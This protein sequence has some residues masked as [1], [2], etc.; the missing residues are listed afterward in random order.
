MVL[1]KQ[2]CR[3]SEGCKHRQ[4]TQNGS[5]IFG[6]LWRWIS[7]CKIGPQCSSFIN[8][9]SLG[10]WVKPGRDSWNCHVSK[11]FLKLNLSIFLWCLNEGGRGIQK[12]YPEAFVLSLE[13]S[14]HRQGFP[15]SDLHFCSSKYGARIGSMNIPPPTPPPQSLELHLNDSQVT[16]HTE[17]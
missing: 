6:T 2:F 13:T 3:T 4:S 14:S 8:V 15:C 1:S 11:V 17:V 10:S 7:S 12:R 9:H 5:W 16:V